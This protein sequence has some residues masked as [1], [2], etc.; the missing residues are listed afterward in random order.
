VQYVI[1]RW[2]CLACGRHNATEVALDGTGKCDHCAVV[3]RIQPSQARGGETPAEL[4]AF[5]RADSPARPA[6]T[7]PAALEAA[8]ARATRE[9]GPPALRTSFSFPFAPSPRPR[10]PTATGDEANDEVVPIEFLRDDR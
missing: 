9:G 10:T 4:A 3:S 1:R 6:A 5:L 2:N 8:A 7:D